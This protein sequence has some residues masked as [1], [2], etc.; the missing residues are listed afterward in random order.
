MEDTDTQLL[1]EA[2]QAVVEL[3]VRYRLAPFAD[4]LVLGPERDLAFN[5]YALARG[6]LLQDGI[7]T[8]DADLATMRGLRADM[9][10][11]ADTAALVDVA[12]RIAAGL[13]RVGLAA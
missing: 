2:G 6:R 12:L 9:M 11:A 13:T 7:I 1:R 8:T 3:D 4:R 10:G 5:A